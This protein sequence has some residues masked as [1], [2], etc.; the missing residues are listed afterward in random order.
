MSPRPTVETLEQRAERVK[1]KLE[2]R[3]TAQAARGI[4]MA[5]ES[6][7]VHLSNAL[8]ELDAMLSDDDDDE[9]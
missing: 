1:R 7:K 6:F 3:I 9:G 2:R 5:S 4:A 8:D